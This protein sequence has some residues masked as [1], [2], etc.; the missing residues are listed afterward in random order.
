M[1]TP[2]SAVTTKPAGDMSL[3]R[4]TV[5]DFKPFY[6]APYFRDFSDEFVSDH[7]RYRYVCLRPII[8]FVNVDIGAADGCLSKFYEHVIGSVIGLGY[9]L[10]PNPYFRLGL[11]ERLH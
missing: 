2:R 10:H 6:E 4:D 8:P 5:T 9:I 11:D 7:H 1:S 3:A